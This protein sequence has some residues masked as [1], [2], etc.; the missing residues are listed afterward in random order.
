MNIGDKVYC[1]PRKQFGVIDAVSEN[2][3]Y[4]VS[5]FQGIGFWFNRKELTEGT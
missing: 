1:I 4:F 3:R 2:G 5:F